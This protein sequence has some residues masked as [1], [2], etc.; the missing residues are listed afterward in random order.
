M[1]EAHRVLAIALHELLQPALRRIAPRKVGCR[2]AERAALGLLD[3]RVRAEDSPE[4]ERQADEAFVA[5]RDR[6]A[7]VPSRMLMVSAS[8]PASGK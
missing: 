4:V 7:A 5:H 2:H 1:R 6:L 8:A 3:D